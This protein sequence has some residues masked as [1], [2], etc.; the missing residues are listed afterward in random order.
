MIA[1]ALPPEAE[2]AIEHIAQERHETATDTA[3]ALLLDAVARALED[4]EDVV[5]AEFKEVK[6]DA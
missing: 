5:D 1:L 4:A 2:R 6:R 3:T